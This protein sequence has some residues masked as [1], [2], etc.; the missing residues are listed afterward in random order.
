MAMRRP[1]SEDKQQAILNRR[2]TWLSGHR[3]RR[4]NW[5]C[6]CCSC[7]SCWR[8]AERCLCRHHVLPLLQLTA[9]AK[10]QPDLSKT[11]N[12]TTKVLARQAAGAEKEPTPGR[13]KR[14]LLLEMHAAAG[15][16]C[17]CRACPAQFMQKCVRWLCTVQ[18]ST[19]HH[20][21]AQHSTT[22]RL[23]R[24]AAGAERTHSRNVPR[25]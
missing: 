15:N 12:S 2:G 9:V 24:Q 1:C 18:H 7:C 11:A 25:A 5:K 17:S 13:F 3:R 8:D 16:A 20:S 6:R 19:A 14:P 10:L 22:N 23:Q 4:S 21:T